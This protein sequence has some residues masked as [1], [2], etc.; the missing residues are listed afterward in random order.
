MNDNH[1]FLGIPQYPHHQYIGVQDQFAFKDANL[2]IVSAQ[3]QVLR[4]NYILSSNETLQQIRGIPKGKKIIIRSESAKPQRPSVDSETLKSQ[5]EGKNAIGA[6]IATIIKS[7]PPKENLSNV[8]GKGVV[9]AQNMVNQTN[10]RLS[11]NLEEKKTVPD[12]H[13]LGN[14]HKNKIDL[15]ESALFKDDVLEE[16]STNPINSSH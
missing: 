10:R 5:N 14:N 9:I 4:E 2:N 7:I 16:F 11:L 1:C 3:Q 6:H 8:S 12:R 15:Q 13:S